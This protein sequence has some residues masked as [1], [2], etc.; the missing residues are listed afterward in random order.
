MSLLLG[1]CG[2]ASSNKAA[3]S[4]ADSGFS[5][6]SELMSMSADVSMSTATT[7]QSMPAAGSNEAPVGNQSSTTQAG[8]FQVPGEAQACRRLT[9]RLG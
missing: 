2:S 3:D 4:K 5:A 1:G 8:D 9:P 7:E 6:E